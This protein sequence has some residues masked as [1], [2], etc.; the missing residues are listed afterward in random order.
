[1]SPARYHEDVRLC[2]LGVTY[3]VAESIRGAL[4][5]PDH[6]SHRAGMLSSVRNELAYLREM[7]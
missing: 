5:D 3:F 4:S 1:M 7:D 6:D 2:L